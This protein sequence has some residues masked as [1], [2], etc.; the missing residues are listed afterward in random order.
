MYTWNLKAHKKH[1]KHESPL[2]KI[3]EKA[4]HETKKKK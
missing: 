4:W 3:A 2:E 1:E